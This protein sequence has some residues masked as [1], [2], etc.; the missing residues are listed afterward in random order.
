[1]IY[2]GYD[3]ALRRSGNSRDRDRDTYKKII[4]VVPHQAI[5]GFLVDNHDEV[6][7]SPRISR[8]LAGDDSDMV[9]RRS[10]RRQSETMIYTRTDITLWTSA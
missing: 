1:M 3:K 4:V 10:S 2:I 8:I 5:E 6:Q 7:F 9:P